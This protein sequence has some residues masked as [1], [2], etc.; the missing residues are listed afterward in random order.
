MITMGVKGL[1]G[2]LGEGRNGLGQAINLTDQAM[3]I[4]SNFQTRQAIIV[5]KTRAVQAQ[6]NS[7][8]PKVRDQ[9]CQSVTLLEGC[10]FTGIPA[11]PE[12][13]TL[14]EEIKGIVI[15]QL[16]SVHNDLLQFQNQLNSLRGK[17][18]SF[19]WA[20]WVAA[21][22][23]ILLSLLTLIIMYGVIAAWNRER[24]GMDGMTVA[25]C[26]RGWFIGPIFVFLVIICWI[27]SMVFVIGSLVTS[28]VCNNSP[29]TFTMVSHRILHDILQKESQK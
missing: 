4:V 26:L 11:A 25:S 14:F 2:S 13:Q 3:V 23:A 6:A 12:L 5:N 1:S 19:N 17:L 24:K 21:G 16:A 10:N 18:S 15:Q 9:V 28:D 8:C 7:I 29:D 20:F 22:F 27:F